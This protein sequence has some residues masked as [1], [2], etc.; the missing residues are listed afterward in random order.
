MVLLF[1]LTGDPAGVITANLC[2]LRYLLIYLIYKASILLG[3]YT[4]IV[5]LCILFPLF[6][7]ILEELLERRDLF[8]GVLPGGHGDGPHQRLIFLFIQMLVK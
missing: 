7:E 8:L 3:F 6:L 4:Y 5:L 2:D 1:D